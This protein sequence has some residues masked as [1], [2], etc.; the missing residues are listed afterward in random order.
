MEVSLEHVSSSRSRERPQWELGEQ[1]QTFHTEDLTGSTPRR[2][3][4]VLVRVVY[5]YPLKKTIN[6]KTERAIWRFL[7]IFSGE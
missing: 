6:R 5:E 1:D 4:G 3:P 7:Q 2:A